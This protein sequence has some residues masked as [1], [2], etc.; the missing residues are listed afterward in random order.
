MGGILLL[1]ADTLGRTIMRPYEVPVGLVMSVI[2]APFFIYL[3]RRRD[4]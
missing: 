4:S 3:L 2:G 1:L